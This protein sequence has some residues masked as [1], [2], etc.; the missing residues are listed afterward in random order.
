MGHRYRIEPLSKKHDRSSFSC[1]EKAL[2]YYL[3]ETA[4][5]DVARHVTAVFLLLDTTK[6]DK[7]AGFYS[8]SASS[9]QLSDLSKVMQK[10]LPKYPNI[11]VALIGRLATDNEYRGVGYGRLLLVDALERAHSISSQLGTAAVVVDPKHSEAEAFYK[12][13]GFASL[14]D[15]SGR[16]IIAMGTIKQLFRREFTV[17]E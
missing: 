10:Q 14:P 1:E 7:I 9:V 17:P 13:F 3:R 6:N 11:P 5:Q 15:L 16:L 4:G 8:L 2:E 12:H